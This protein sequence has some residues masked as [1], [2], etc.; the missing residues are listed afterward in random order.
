MKKICIFAEFPLSALKGELTGRG[1]D[2]AA[3]WLPQLAKAWESIEDFEIHWGVFDRTAKCIETISCWNQFFHRLPCPGISVS[4]LLGRSPHKRSAK[5]LI[6]QIRPDLIHCWGT[7]TLNSSAFFSFKGPS[8]LSMQGIVTTYHNTGYLKGWRWWLFRYWEKASLQ[9]ASI[10]T[11]ESE[12]GLRQ[13]GKIISGKNLRK[14]EYGVNPSYY[15]VKWQPDSAS[16]RILFVGGLNHLKGVDIL[17]EMLRCNPQRNWTM[18]FVGSGYLAEQLHS[19]N[20]PRVEVLGILKTT[21]V[22]TEMAKAWALVMPSRAD[23]SPNV[24]KESRVIGLPIVGSHHGGHAEYIKNALDGYLVET[25]DPN[26]WYLALNKLGTDFDL[27]RRLGTQ[28]HEWFCDHFRPEKTADEFAKLYR[29]LL[30]N[31]SGFKM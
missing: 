12:W 5:K 11:S 30:S 28:R 6:Q 23:T 21:E 9:K 14:I 1:G 19:L 15:K 18:V 26:S 16:P 2:Q 13:V 20:D 17:L 27:C 29:E 24:V 25:E 22:Q 4:L 10:V 31:S 8:I 7:E 3:T